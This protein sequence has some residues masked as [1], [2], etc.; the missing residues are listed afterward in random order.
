MIVH[1][2][3]AITCFMFSSTFHLFTAHS[4]RSVTFFSKL[5]YG[6]ISI[7][8]AGST[9]PLIQYAFACYT[10]IRYIYVS[11]ISLFCTVSFI[12]T[13]LPNADM[14]KYRRLRGILFIIVGLLAGVPALHAAIT[15][16]PNIMVNFYY[17]ALGGI[18]YI[19]G[20]L[21]YVARIPER[22]APGKFDYFVL[23]ACEA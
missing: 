7:L 18:V 14:P 17:W 11:L 16:D 3:C 15:N 1:M 2:A 10:T 4:S 8:I 19:T 22:C 21:I 5:D 23:A 9:F 13:M 12:V 20:A 6:G